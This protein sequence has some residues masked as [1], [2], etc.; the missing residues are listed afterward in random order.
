M[1]EVTVPVAD[2]DVAWITVGHRGEGGVPVDVI[3]DFAGAEHHWQ[4]LAVR[5]GGAVDSRS[6]MVPV[7]VEIPDPYERSGDRPALVEGMFVEVV[8]TAAPPA[9]AVVIPRTALRP[10]DRVWVVDAERALRIRDVT[11]A[12]AGV[13]QA[14][15]TDGLAA[16]DLVC[17]S[18]LQYVTDGLPVRIEGEP[19][20]AGP[21]AD[22]VAAD[23]RTAKDGE[24]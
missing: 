18:N 19:A 7:V 10:G 21:P 6:R 14:V 2:A 22:D 5:L 15:V 8:F 12:R 1:A 11:V 24:R 4:G 9:G 13:E 17:T 20:S 16:G 23:A 3:A